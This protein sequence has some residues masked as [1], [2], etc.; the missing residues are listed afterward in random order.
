[1]S[2]KKGIKA[3]DTIYITKYALTR[4]LLKCVVDSVSAT[5][6]FVHIEGKHGHF[7]FNIRDV[8]TTLE[9]ASLAFAVKRSKRIKN[10]KAQIKKLDALYGTPIKVEVWGET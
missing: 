6:S 2:E 4:G 3:G 10:L 5:G 1:M 9:A 8:E 7:T